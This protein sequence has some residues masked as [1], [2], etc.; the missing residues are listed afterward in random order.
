[1]TASLKS[2]NILLLILLPALVTGG[3]LI[4]AGNLSDGLRLG[5]LS[6]PGVIFT[7]F[8]ITRRKTYWYIFSLLWWFIFLLDSLLRSSTWFL[9]SSDSEAYFIIEAIANTNRQE[10]WEF[11]QLHSVAVSTVFISLIILIALHSFAV[12]KLIKVQHVEQIWQSKIF[13]S[14]IILLTVLSLTSYLMKPSR[15]VHP[16]I[17]WT[18]YQTKIQDFRGR[19]KQHKNVHKQWDLSA[20]KNLVM[21]R[22]AKGKQ[23]H[24]LVLSESLTSLNL[25]ICG[26]PRDTTPELNKRLSEIKVFCNAFSPS[27]STINALRV[28]LTESPA[29][30]HKKYSPESVLA[31]ARAAGYKIY[32]LSNQDDSYLSS[33]FGSYA[34]QAIYKNT[35]SGRSSSSLDENLLPI[36]QQ[37]L[38][39][40]VE[41]KLIILHLIG[42]HPNYQER[43]PT[44][45]NKFNSNSNDRVESDLKARNIDPWIRS[46]RNDYDNAVLYEDH[47]LAKMLDTLRADHLPDFRSFTVVSDHGNEVGHE[48]DYAGHS[49]TTKAGY[50]VPVIMWSDKLNLT[51]VNKDTNLNTAELDQNLMHIMGLKD[52]SSS[53]HSYWLE[54]DYRFT[55]EANWPYWENKS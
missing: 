42:T 21:T 45:F 38:A 49:P 46:L 18:E 47:L 14:F 23:T 16:L 17:F 27:P 12:F 8:A 20:E 4:V 13:R 26:Y 41:K 31:Y 29:S 32:W 50:Q 19:V 39:D 40:P 35:R 33:L 30:E 54:Q 2:F 6:L 53:N 52:K 5:F 3:L 22:Q 48:L 55:P 28:L 37:A 24:V 15:K 25:G 43:Y 9:F 34:D 7:Y 36:Y 11:L 44:T 10:I 1:M 51:G